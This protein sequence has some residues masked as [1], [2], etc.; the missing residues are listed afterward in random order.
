VQNGAGDKGCG[1]RNGEFPFGNNGN[2]Q[3]SQTSMNEKERRK[4]K[5]RKMILCL[6]LTIALPFLLLTGCGDKEEDNGTY[7]F[8]AGID[9][10]GYWK[11][12]K[13]LDYVELFDYEGLSIPSDVHEISDEALQEAIDTLLQNYSTK[14][15]IKDRAIAEGDNVNIDYVGSVD[16]AEFPGGS[17]N[18]A[19]TDV[20][21][22]STNYIDDFLTQIIGHTPGE[23]FDV[24]V[25]FPDDYQEATL[26]GKD[27]VFVTTINYIA[28]AILPELTDEFVAS[29]L[30]ADYG[31][32]TV[33]EM[34]EGQREQFR[35]QSIQ[36]YL[37]NYLVTEVKVS[38]VPDKLIE[39]QEQYML[40][41]YKRSAEENDM[42][43]EEL[44]TQYLGV[45]NEEELL[46]GARENNVKSATYTLVC[47]AIA[48]DMK[49]SIKDSDLTDYFTEFMGSGDYSTYEA[50]YGLP[51]LKQVVL[52]Q[53][54]FY[55]IIEKAVME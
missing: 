5:N 11:G 43:L 26:Q 54:V 21:A 18:G 51:Y 42:T 35:T 45:S 12:I 8:S 37:F 31:W 33:D 53:K 40:A 16:G 50:D 22:G 7:S 29:N 28:E 24:E 49:L 14:E 19:G 6:L 27:A 32:N 9:K 48:E 2:C 41:D 55:H 46:E 3:Q 17:T 20:V 30:S 39:Y 1:N 10:N 15:Q 13:A 44:L 47:Q 38:S 4:M 52:D 36:N 25:T 34:R 23:T